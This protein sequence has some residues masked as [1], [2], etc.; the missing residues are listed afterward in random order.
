M[1]T[2]TATIVV[3][4]L[5]GALQAC[6][7]KPVESSAPASPAPAPAEAAPGGMAPMADSN[8]AA[9]TNVKGTGTVTA[10]D[11]AAGTITINHEAIAAANWPAMEMAFKV[12]PSVAQGIKVGDRVDFDL[13]LQGGAGEVTASQKQ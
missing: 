1:K 5:A 11:T 9:A 12:A 8:A 6:T 13:R 4:A 2:L 10:L 7:P 3:L